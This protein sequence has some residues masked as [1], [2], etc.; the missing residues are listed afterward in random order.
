MELKTIN[1]HRVPVRYYEGGEGPPL[2]F[3]HGAGGLVMDFQFLDQLALR[4]RNSRRT[5]WR[6]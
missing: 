5:T 3:L 4:E 6:A 2:V 1:T